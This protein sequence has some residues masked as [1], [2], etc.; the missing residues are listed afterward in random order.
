[1][2]LIVI[3][4][5]PASGKST[6]AHQLRQYFEQRHGRTVHIVAENEAIPRAG[7][8][9]NEY[10][11]SSLNEKMVRAD[12]KSAALRLLSQPDAVI[13]LDGGNYIKGYRYELY[14]ASKAARTTQCT[15]YCGI[16]RERA[17]ELNAQRHAA[18]EVVVAGGGGAGDEAPLLD[19]GRVAY[20]AETFEALCQ[21]FEEPHGNSRWDAPLFTVMPD[22]ELDVDG[23][24]GALFESKAPPPNKSTQSVSV[25]GAV[26]W[27]GFR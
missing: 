10:F 21:Q 6:R 17:L 22:D 2:P 1:M 27:F 11:A 15:V 23:I 5:L 4:G 13:I 14:C 25:A 8:A 20:S 16:R 7:F 19:N 24:N 18:D 26:V 3:S 9:K 12:L